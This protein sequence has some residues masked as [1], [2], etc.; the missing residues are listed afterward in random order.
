MWRG[1][2]IMRKSLNLFVNTMIKVLSNI[3]FTLSLVFTFA[4]FKYLLNVVV[5]PRNE[6]LLFVDKEHYKGFETVINFVNT[7]LLLV[8]VA[9]GVVTFFKMLVKKSYISNDVVGINKNANEL[10]RSAVKE[11]LE[12]K[13]NVNYLRI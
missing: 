8:V 13:T 2:K 5:L 1:G 6:L 12:I 9:I 4:V 7:V 11:C 3:I 10:E